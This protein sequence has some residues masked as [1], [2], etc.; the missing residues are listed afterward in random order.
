MAFETLKHTESE[1]KGII[2]EIE[3]K[4]SEIASHKV[5]SDQR[6]NPVDAVNVKDSDQGLNIAERF[7]AKAKGYS[8]PAMDLAKNL[9]ELESGKYYSKEIQKAAEQPP[10]Q[11]SVLKDEGLKQRTINE[12]EVL[13]HDTIN[14]KEFLD[15]KSQCKLDGEVRYLT[16]LERMERGLAPIDKIGKPFNL[17]HIGQKMDSPLAELPDQVHKEK[18]SQL[19]ANKGPS[20]IDRVAFAKE[21]QEYW[22][23][24][25]EQ[26]KGGI[27][28]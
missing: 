24:R 16:N 11:L 18:Y 19:H 9:N 1:A 22:K 20:N 28:A 12:R 13:Q 21:K 17:H 27:S 23:A 4:N 7:V 5:D 8:E 2:G 6:I 25:A 10:E 3:Q 15:I 14:S 26:I